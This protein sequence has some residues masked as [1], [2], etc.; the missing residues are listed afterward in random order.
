MKTMTKCGVTSKMMA[1]TV[2]H[3]KAGRRKS[4]AGINRGKEG[5][6]LRGRVQHL[7]ALVINERRHVEN[8]S[9]K[10]PMITS[11]SLITNNNR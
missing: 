3:S 5:S 11:I 9:I 4:N 8:I 7:V 1:R 6:Q 2:R 10:G